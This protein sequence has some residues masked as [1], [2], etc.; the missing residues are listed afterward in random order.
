MEFDARSG[1]TMHDSVVCGENVSV[2][3]LGGEKSSGDV[4]VL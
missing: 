2:S 1:S 3:V 4:T